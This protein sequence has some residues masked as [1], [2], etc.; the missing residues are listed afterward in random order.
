[1]SG[2]KDRDLWMASG[3]R[4]GALIQGTVL[5]GLLAMAVLELFAI[6][7]GA[8]VFVYQGY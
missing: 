8:A 5:G 4:C 2:E 1:M 6:T 7:S 3:R